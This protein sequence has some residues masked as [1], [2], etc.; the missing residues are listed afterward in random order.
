MRAVQFSDGRQSLETQFRITA[1]RAELAR[2]GLYLWNGL[3]FS[4]R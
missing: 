1:D 3:G 2:R 4:V